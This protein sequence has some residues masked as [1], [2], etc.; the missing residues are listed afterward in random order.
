MAAVVVAGLAGWWWRAG[1]L[2]PAGRRQ[3]RA[4]AGRRLL[5][6]AACWRALP[7]ARGWSPR[8]AGGG[9]R[10]AAPPGQPG[11]GWGGWAGSLAG[12]G[13]VCGWRGFF[14]G[15][16]F[17]AAAVVGCGSCRL[18]IVFPVLKALAAAFF[19]KTANVALALIWERGSEA[20]L[21][22]GLPDGRGQLRRG[23]EHLFLGLMTAASTTCWARFM[24]LM[25]E[26][27]SR[28]LRGR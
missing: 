27:A 7:S 4:A 17:V 2:P 22:P 8:I 5:G 11:I 25:A 3:R 14:R 28:P 18:F 16:L 26:R 23:L 21:W 1:R 6:P 12:A 24:A 9:V 19:G 13:G 15:D 20:Q 10:R